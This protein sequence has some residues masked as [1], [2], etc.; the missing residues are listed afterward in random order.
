MGPQDFGHE[1]PLV[2]G[3]EQ[4]K[5]SEAS[6]THY[7][8]RCGEVISSVPS[9][10]CA[11]VCGFCLHKECAEA[12]F[13]INHPLHRKHPLYLLPNPPAIYEGSFA[14]NLYGEEGPMFVYHCSDCGIGLHIKCALSIYNLAEKMVEQLKLIA[15]KDPMISMKMVTR[16]LGVGNH[17]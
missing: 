3:E 17:Y 9:F 4:R 14:F 16:A 2:F 1:Q 15:C 11:E 5:Q 10:S 12:P 8:S 7:C 6:P 13:K